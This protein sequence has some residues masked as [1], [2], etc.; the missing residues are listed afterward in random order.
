VRIT[1]NV[2]SGKLRDVQA[3]RPYYFDEP[4][5]PVQRTVEAV[6][7]NG[8]IEITVPEVRYHTMIVFRFAK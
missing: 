4:Q 5:Q 3:M 1:A 6:V 2:G 8:R 7:N